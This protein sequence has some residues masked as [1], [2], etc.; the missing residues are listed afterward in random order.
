MFR[1]ELATSP[2]GQ[3]SLPPT[4]DHA[5]RIHHGPPARASCQRHAYHYTR[6]DIDIVPAGTGGTWTCDDPATT[7]AV[8][9]S[10]AMVRR[11]ATEL[12]LDPARVTVTARHQVRDPQ[13]AHVAW[14]LEAEDRAGYPGGRAFADSLGLALSLHVLGAYRAP[15]R[16]GTEL[17]PRQ[18]ARLRDYIEA[19]IDRALSLAELADVL[20][21]STS[22]LK[23]TFKRTTGLAVHEFIIHRR[24]AR[25]RS[26]L[27]AGEP[28][29]QVALAAGFSHQS[30]MA[31]WMRRLLGRTPSTFRPT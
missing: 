3:V 1:V 26:L 19:H 15:V 30:H 25:A 2:I 10:P 13:I 6:G 23:A 18:L 8:S 14:A 17:S 5:I 7:L 22:H 4:R 28:A 11:A 16:A 12:G 29:S 31:R 9:I 21:I 20:A 27:V 24:V